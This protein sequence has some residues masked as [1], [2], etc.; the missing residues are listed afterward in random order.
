MNISCCDCFAMSLP[1]F[2]KVQLHFRVRGPAS[3]TQRCSAR[4]TLLC[5]SLRFVP[6]DSNRKGDRSTDCQGEINL[7]FPHLFNNRLLIQTST[8]NSSFV[9]ALCSLIHEVAP[10]TIPPPQRPS[11]RRSVRGTPSWAWMDPMMEQV[12][13]NCAFVSRKR[14]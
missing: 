10:G 12:P 14:V 13:W 1:P 3:A 6:R 5:L 4:T 2:P 9:N 11:G 7:T 8:T